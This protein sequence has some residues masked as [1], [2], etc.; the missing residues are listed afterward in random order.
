MNNNTI[1][2]NES[3]LRTAPN[4][5]PLLCAIDMPVCLISV[6]VIIVQGILYL[7]K[8]EPVSI[9]PVVILLIGLIFSFCADHGF[10]WMIGYTY[11]PKDK[12]ASYGM[13]GSLSSSTKTTVKFKQVE[14]AQVKKDEIIV[15]GIIEKCIPRQRPKTLHKYVIPKGF[16][17]DQQKQI[18]QSLTE[19]EA[20]K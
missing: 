10:N 20:K 19:R 4:M 14:S 7:L 16:T 12:K 3:K 9:I 18:I 13:I 5:V 8:G 17:E 2:R 15:T 1:Q 6:I 11:D